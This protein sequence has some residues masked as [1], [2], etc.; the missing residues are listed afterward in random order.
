VSPLP[1]LPK[2]ELDVVNVTDAEPPGFLTL[3]RY[4]LAVVTKEKRSE[5]FRYDVVDRRALDAAVM[6]AHTVGQTG[7]DVY[8]RS[9]VRPP[10]GLRADAKATSESV[11][12]E[13]PAGLIEPGEEPRAAAARELEEELGFAIKEEDLQPLGPWAYPAPGFIAEIHHFFHVRV[14]P[15][16]QRA[17]GGDGSPLEEVAVIVRVSLKDAIE[18]CKRGLIRDEKTE[19]ALRRL[20]DELSP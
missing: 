15:G 2:V 18:A 11:T 5:P 9:A 6:V 12:W 13:V 17:P 4:D 1:E 14:D 3:H 8:L 20:V 16:A 7:I 19:L 10:I